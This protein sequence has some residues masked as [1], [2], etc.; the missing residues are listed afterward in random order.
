MTGSS[1]HNIDAFDV[2]VLQIH[3]IVFAFDGAILVVRLLDMR[4]ADARRTESTNP[5]TL[6]SRRWRERNRAKYLDTHRRDMAASRVRR[7]AV[8]SCK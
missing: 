3:N 2:V 4:G 6:R 8:K 7:R 5:A 1:C